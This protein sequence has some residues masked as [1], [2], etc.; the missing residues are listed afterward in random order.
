MPAISFPILRRREPEMERPFRTGRGPIIGIIAAIQ[1]G[2]RQ[3]V[4]AG[5]ALRTGRGQ[6]VIVG[7]WTVVAFRIDV[8]EYNSGF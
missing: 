8:P 2:D 5:Y 1:R 4:L 3:S 7:I 6:V